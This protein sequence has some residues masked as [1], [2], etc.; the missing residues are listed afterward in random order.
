MS[1]P[2][3]DPRRRGAVARTVPLLA[4]AMPLLLAVR[5]GG[6]AFPFLSLLYA[7]SPSFASCILYKL[8]KVICIF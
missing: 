4:P 6:I 1:A 7:I 3:D 8:T 2:L 5:L